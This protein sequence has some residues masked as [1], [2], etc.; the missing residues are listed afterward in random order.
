LVIAV[1]TSGS[2]DQTLL[3]QFG[4]EIRAVVDEVQPTRVHVMYADARVKP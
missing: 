2:I 4:D 1:D 3:A